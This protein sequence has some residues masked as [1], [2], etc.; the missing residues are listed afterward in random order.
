MET[1]LIKYV[2]P[3]DNARILAIFDSS[4]IRIYDTKPLRKKWEIFEWLDNQEIHNSVKVDCGGYGII[5]NSE[6]DLSAAEIYD[7]GQILI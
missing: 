1:K 4:E 7:N 3:L 2:T 6:L 5:W